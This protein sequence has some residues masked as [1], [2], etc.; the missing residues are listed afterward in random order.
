MHSHQSTELAFRILVDG[1]VFRLE[2]NSLHLE[3][4]QHAM[5]LLFHLYT[6]TT[7]THDT[8]SVNCSPL[9]DAIISIDQFTLHLVF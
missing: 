6:H 5:L 2:R 7:H 8:C 9:N 4:L 1:D 3:R